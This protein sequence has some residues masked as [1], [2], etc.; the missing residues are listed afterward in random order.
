MQVRLKLKRLWLSLI[1]LQ[2]VLLLG[3]CSKTKSTPELQYMPDMARGPS[4]KAQQVKADPAYTSLRGPVAGT[5]S[6][7]YEPYPF[8]TVDTVGP[9]R[10]L[11]NPLPR[12]LQVLETGRK[13][14]NTYCIVCHGYKGDGKG[15]IVPKFPAPPSLLTEKI[16]DWEDGRIY[17]IVT[18]GRGNMPS[19]AGQLEPEQ[20]W[21]IAHY[22]RALYRAAHPTEEDLK[23]MQEQKLDILFYKDEPDTSSRV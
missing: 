1:W 7:D 9:A 18:K 17:H 3:S 13:Y 12:S 5:I 22:V 15:Y 23:M 14:Y 10:Q 6:L 19:Y 4:L 21:A 11:F 2:A 20:R 16:R 8:A